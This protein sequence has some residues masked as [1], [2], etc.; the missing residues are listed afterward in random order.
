MRV[1]AQQT[2]ITQME[3]TVATLVQELEEERSEGIRK[4]SETG[5]FILCIVVVSRIVDVEGDVKMSSRE[6]VLLDSR[7]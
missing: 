2:I 1:E 6:L 7:P 5:I 3:E 4:D